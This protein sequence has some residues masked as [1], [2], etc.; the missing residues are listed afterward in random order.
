VVIVGGSTEG[1]RGCSSSI[2]VEGTEPL[3]SLAI[4]TESGTDLC[5][6]NVVCGDGD[7][8]MSSGLIVW[9]TLPSW[10]ATARADP[11]FPTVEKP[12]S[13]WLPHTHRI[14]KRV[15]NTRDIL[16]WKKQ[17]SITGNSCY[18]SHFQNKHT[19]LA[20]YITRWQYPLSIVQISDLCFILL[21]RTSI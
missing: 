18:S 12:S 1:G 16:N 19:T 11:T 5:I 17:Y 6:W 20:H 13:S 21:S 8:S 7:I 3:P 2:C 10:F 14:M 9:R 4:L 15:L